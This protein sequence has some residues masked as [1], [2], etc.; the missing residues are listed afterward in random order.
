MTRFPILLVSWKKQHMAMEA[1]VRLRMRKWSLAETGHV[2]AETIRLAV[3]GSI[4]LAEIRSCLTSLRDPVWRSEG[5]IDYLVPLIETVVTVSSWQAKPSVF[6]KS[7]RGQ[8]RE[9]VVWVISIRG[10]T[11]MPKSSQIQN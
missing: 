5:R 7:P 8:Q 2:C 6:R 9:E 11:S 3:S 4:A 1:P 10:L